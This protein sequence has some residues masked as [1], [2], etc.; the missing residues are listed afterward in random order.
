MHLIGQST[1][2]APGIPL[3]GMRYTWKPLV[4][5]G[6]T[7]CGMDARYNDAGANKPFLR[8]GQVASDMLNALMRMATVIRHLKGHLSLTSK[9]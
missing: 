5:I 2:G 8:M 1:V 7:L 6:S 4:G 3:A 9:G